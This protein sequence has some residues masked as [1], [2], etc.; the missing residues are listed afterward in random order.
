MTDTRKVVK[1]FLASPGDLKDE[2][3]IAKSVVDE[4][5]SAWADN[6]GYQVEL[7]GWEDTVSGSGRPQAIINRDLERCELFIGLLWKRWGSPPDSNGPFGSGFEEEYRTSRERQAS[8]GRPEI[9]LYFRDIPDDAR[10]D[11]GEQLKRVMAFRDELVAGKEQLFETFGDLRDF[12]AKFRRCVTRYVQRLRA[13]E[14]EDVSQR[15]QTPTTGGEN[16]TRAEPT[17]MESTTP[18]SDEGTSFLLA[19][20]EKLRGGSASASEIARFR[21]LSTLVGERGNDEPALGVHDANLLFLARDEI[22]FGSQEIEGLL[23]CGLTF[24]SNENVP[25]WRWVERLSGF[26]SNLLVLYALTGTPRRIALGALQAMRLIGTQLGP[27]EPF[28]RDF[29]LTRWLTPGLPSENRVAAL[30]YLYD[31]GITSDLPLV[32]AEFERNDYQTAAAAADTIIAISLRDARHTAL[33]ALY[34]LQPARVKQELVTA[35]FESV[36]PLDDESLT[37]GLSHAAATVRRVVVR[38]LKERNT[39]GNDV[40]TQL[41]EDSDATVRLQALLALVHGGRA[42]SDIEAKGIIV[43]PDRRGTYAFLGFGGSDVDGE[44]KLKDFRHLRLGSLKDAELKGIVARES[45]LDQSAFFVLAARH[46]KRFKTRIRMAVDDNAA[47]VV[48]DGLRALTATLAGGE[49]T[50]SKAMSLEPSLRKEYSRAA[51]RILARNGGRGDL[52][53]MRDAI[54]SSIV[55][56]TPDDFEYLGRYGEWADIPLIVDMAKASGG[57]SSLL[58]SVWAT[59]ETIDAAAKAMLLLGGLRFTEVLAID[60]PQRLLVRV[61]LRASKRAFASLADVDISKLLRS[62]SDAV[63]KAAA[64]KCVHALSKHRAATLLAAHLDG[65]STVYYNVVHWLDFGVSAPKSVASS[66]ADRALRALTR[67]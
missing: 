41:L 49:D 43:K 29:L 23:K 42:V 59:D 30:E 24:F 45:I 40:A 60:V 6:L 16:P 27:D 12:E 4:F 17:A 37:P 3:R 18:L 10:R 38:L 50:I 55:E 63:R 31:W 67:S 15:D 57:G 7:V 39:L 25:L 14:S 53:R 34:E 48:S 44:E 28:G 51:R 58:G 47:A 52:N 56:P 13:N 26:E 65:S 21:L 62:D 1:V 2:R 61:I 20:M 46:F 66:A 9:S 11:P 35:I 19:L 54:R 36:P 22:L 5:N 33:S 32:K 8:A 64:L